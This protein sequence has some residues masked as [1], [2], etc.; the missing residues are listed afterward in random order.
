[1]TGSPSD[2]TPLQGHPSASLADDVTAVA[3]LEE[4]TRRRLYELVAGAPDDVGRDEAARTIG[5]SRELA[6][7]HLDRLVE[8]GL[9]S[10]VYRRLTGRRGPGAGRPAKLYRRSE[11]E[12]SVD[13]PPRRYRAIAGMFADGLAALS[14]RIGAD[15]VAAAVRESARERGRLAGAGARA[16]GG[17][18]PTRDGLR[19]ALG[20]ILGQA[21]YEPK[22][23]DRGA[24]TLCNCPYRAVAGAQRD[25]TCGA[26]FAWAEGVVEGLGADVAVAEFTPAP[27]RCCVTFAEA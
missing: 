4:P 16:T 1:M 25:L 26:N 11:R 21:G 9:L 12:I 22:M 18:R 7:F 5:I 13:L 6:A 3:L 24:I 23:D 2:S 15:A 27:G 17:P 20:D 10:A 19:A 14:D 8:A